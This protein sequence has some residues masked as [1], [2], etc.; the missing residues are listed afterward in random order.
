MHLFALSHVGGL[1][2][3]FTLF[4]TIPMWHHY[5]AE[6]PGAHWKYE[7]ANGPEWWGSIKVRLTS[8]CSL[9]T[10]F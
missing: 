10:H 7:G 6:S 1:L 5:A 9:A 4:S 3:A 8:T 2:V